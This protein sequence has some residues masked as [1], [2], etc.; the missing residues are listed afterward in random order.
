MR[1]RMSGSRMCLCR[2][3]AILLMP[4]R[5]GIAVRKVL[6]AY[7]KKRP[8]TNLAMKRASTRRILVR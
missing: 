3:I 5:A 6:E 4:E 7:V 2:H 1:L 8:L